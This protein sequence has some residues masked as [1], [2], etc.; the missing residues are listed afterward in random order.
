MGGSGRVGERIGD[1][2]R[3]H[4]LNKADRMPVTVSLSCLTGVWGAPE[5][6]TDDTPRCVCTHVCS[7]QGC[8]RRASVR[9][10]THTIVLFVFYVHT[11]VFSHPSTPSVEEIP[12]LLYI[13][14]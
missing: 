2:V 11:R 1:V 14:K 10:H 3:Q 6:W 12:K 4:C 7:H 8:G 5:R 13:R 9:T